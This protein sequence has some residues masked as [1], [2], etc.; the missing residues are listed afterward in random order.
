MKE[1]TMEARLRDRLLTPQELVDRWKGSITA[2]TLATWRSRKQGPKYV[3]VGGRVL[4]PMEGVE[5]YEKKR[6][7][8]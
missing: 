2:V 6:T 1:T 8:G 4:Y 3:K 5:E 7:F